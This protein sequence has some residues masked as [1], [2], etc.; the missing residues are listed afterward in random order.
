MKDER[1]TRTFDVTVSVRECAE[2]DHERGTTSY[3]RDALAELQKALTAYGMGCSIEYSSGGGRATIKI[4][5]M[6][7]L[8]AKHARTRDAGRYPINVKWPEESGATDRERLAWCTSQSVDE[9][10]DALGVSRRTA[11]RR[12][13]DL[14]EKVRNQR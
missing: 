8:R 14:R 6:E 10:A 12:L 1:N 5:H 4:D 9:L 13:A 2:C 7:P 3:G 11:Q